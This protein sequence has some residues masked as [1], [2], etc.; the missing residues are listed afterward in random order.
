M[1]QRT[2]AIAHACALRVKE[3]VGW[4]QGT[5]VIA[6]VMALMF[7]AATGQAIWLPGRTPSP[8]HRSRAAHPGKA[9]VTTSAAQPA[10]AAAAQPAAAA[11]APAPQPPTVP[12]VIQTAFTP[13]GPDAVNWALRVSSCESQ[14]NPQAVNAST[15][16]AGLF[17]FLPSTWDS[18]PYAASS[19]FDPTANA[20][21]AAWL[22]QTSGPSQWQCS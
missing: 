2:Y 5:R 15:G 21:A 8:V 4:S 22:Y 19:P 16:A 20:Q 13:L 6:M 1:I 10:P 18:S 12:Q 9:A 17:Q 3:Q 14:Y 7:V 11:P